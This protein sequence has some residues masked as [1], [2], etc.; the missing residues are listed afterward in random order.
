MLTR[1]DDYPLHQTPEPV[2]IAQAERN[3][4]DRY[5]FNGYSADG[6]LFFAAALGVYPQLDIID[7]AFC[8][9]T[10]G[11]Q[12]NLR[13]SRRLRGERLD[14]QVGPIRVEVVEPLQRL[15]LIVGDNASPLRADLTF[16]ARHAAI[17]E[18]RFTRRQGARLQMDYTRLTQ[19]GGW[20]GEVTVAGR[21]LAIDPARHLGTRDRSW[22]IRPIGAPESQ[23][24]PAAAAP[25][26]WWLWMPLNF[27]DASAFFHSNDDAA[28]AAWNRRGAI[29][30]DGADPREFTVADIGCV[31]HP[32]TRRLSRVQLEPWPG[33]S[34]TVTPRGPA[35]F[36]SGLGYLHPS[37]GHG[38][39]HGA[40]PAVAYDVASAGF[41]T[42]PGLANLHVQVPADAELV[43][44][45]RMRRGHGAVEQLFL[46]PHAASG[47]TGMLEP[48]R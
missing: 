11:V 41:E 35:F 44:D 1:G 20:S 23:P 5:F 18:P 6:T 9:M 39:D 7:A 17:E 2:A 47:L 10:E 8:V 15:R 48:S 22:G 27:P 3:F 4:Y 43:I 16:T 38:M 37:W 42:P 14:L 34:L 45:G 32:G 25:Q 21:T 36:M 40:E 28:G 13:A 26:F 29:V 19:N 31:Y 12:H 24:A 33:C 46:G 30:P